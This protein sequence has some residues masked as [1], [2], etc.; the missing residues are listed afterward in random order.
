MSEHRSPIRAR[1]SC[2][3]ATVPAQEIIEIVD[4]TSIS[5]DASGNNNDNNDNNGDDNDIDW[6]CLK[7]LAGLRKRQKPKRFMD[8]AHSSLDRGKDCRRIRRTKR[9]GNCSN[10]IK[11]D[12][13]RCYKCQRKLMGRSIGACVEKPCLNLRRPVKTSSASANAGKSVKGQTTVPIIIPKSHP[14]KGDM[15]YAKYTDDLGYYWG[16]V[17]KRWVVNGN[18]LYSVHFDDGDKR[19][20][21][22][23]RQIR[24]VEEFLL[25][26]GE[27][28]FRATANVDLET[29]RKRKRAAEVGSEDDRKLPAHHESK[30]ES[31]IDASETTHGEH[32]KL[33]IFVHPLI[34]K[35]IVRKWLDA[36]FQTRCLPGIVRHCWNNLET[37]SIEVEV[38]YPMDS[39]EEEKKLTPG[40]EIPQRELIPAEI[41]LGC[42][43]IFERE[44]G[45]PISS[46][47]D[48]SIPVQWIVPDQVDDYPTLPP[49]RRLVVTEKNLVIELEA[50]TSN[51]PGAG[52]GVFAK[53]SHL[54]NESQV[55]ES[56]YVLSRGEWIDLGIYSP[57]RLEDLQHE[58][59]LIVKSFIFDSKPE[60]WIFGQSD[61]NRHY[62]F[63]ITDSE[64]GDLHSLAKTNV[65][66]YVNETDGKE[67]PLIHSRR[68]PFSHVHYLLGPADG[69][70]QLSLPFDEWIELLIDYGSSYESM[71]ILKGYSRLPKDAQKDVRDSDSK[72]LLD[73]SE[74]PLPEI[75]EALVIM[76]ELRQN[77][78]RMKLRVKVRFLLV[79][80]CLFVRIQKSNRGNDHI[81]TM[82]KVFC[83]VLDS[84]SDDGLRE[85]FEGFRK[86][87]THSDPMENDIMFSKFLRNLIGTSC[88]IP[89][90]SLR[91][92]I[93]ET[94]T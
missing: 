54:S 2:S 42:R 36:S 74:W 6:K 31:S 11:G 40:W 15:V 23:R 65:V 45:F 16:K 73:I 17:T 92:S 27:D 37:D 81:P 49:K 13:G 57:L 60:G 18:L 56:G 10:C 84:V 72:T 51:I 70:E 38:E 77:L 19:H 7:E 66:V 30:D 50:R 71:R 12:C 89:A 90:S 78:E 5:S 75:E 44:N 69:V 3:V 63:D 43:K 25:D 61:D 76:Y 32:K 67:S 26:F 64:S 8:E 34:N 80:L 94:L 14:N 48:R 47:V 22:P 87:F 85:T 35:C 91:R 39:W 9:C 79:G 1:K 88:T 20:R 86:T 59:A 82:K 55:N 41:A 83:D 52:W 28:Y 24:S 68:D 21:V 29:Y 4:S 62:C 46:I 58:A 53:A 93:R 33:Q